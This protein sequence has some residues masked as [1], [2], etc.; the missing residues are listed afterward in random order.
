[1]QRILDNPELGDFDDI[2]VLEN[3]TKEMMEIEIEKLF[4]SFKPKNLKDLLLF[5]FSGHGIRDDEGKLYL[6]AHNT[7]KQYPRATAVASSFL[8]DLMDKCR[9]KRQVVILDCCFSAAFTQ[10]LTAKDAGTIDIKQLLGGEGRAILTSSTSTQYSFEQD[11]TELSIYTQYLIEGI[12]TGAADQNQDGKFSVDELHQYARQ[13]IDESFPQMKPEIYAIGEGYNIFLAKNPKIIQP[14]EEKQ[15]DIIELLLQKPTLTQNEIEALKKILGSHLGNEEQIPKTTTVPTSDDDLSLD[16]LSLDKEQSKQKKTTFSDY[17]DIPV[18]LRRQLD[19]EQPKPKK[20]TSSDYLDIP[21]FLRRQ[22]KYKPNNI[23]RDKLKNGSLG[24]EMVIVLAGTFKMGDIQGIGNNGEKPVHEVSVKSFAIGRYQITVAEFRQFVEATRYKTEAEKG[25][26]AYVW[27]DGKWQQVKSVNWRKPYFLQ[28]DNQPV[29]CVSWND[30]MAYINWLSEQT[31]KIYH[32]PSEAEWEYAARAGTETDYWWGNEIGKNKANCYG[33]GSQWSGKQ[34]APVGS[35]EPNPFDL[36]DTVG[37]VWEWC[38]DSWHKN[39]KNAPTDGSIWEKNGDSSLRV[40]RGGTWYSEP[41][42]VR[43]SDRYRW[44]RD[45]RD[46]NGG[47]R[48][49]ARTL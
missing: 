34:T 45:Y 26:G 18:F 38:A 37:N 40:V 22:S 9:S 3:P 2:K 31:G 42:Y 17:S 5:Y 33:S 24:T 6:A 8:H 11:N 47:F 13:K 48:V 36:Y 39:Y 7:Q 14:D 23:F 29:V 35:F 10:G 46:Y 4:P 21:D 12:E 30:A 32:L 15:I 49:A 1:M 27:K 19:E 20:T 16:D 28:Q 25:D 41:R 44:T 43:V